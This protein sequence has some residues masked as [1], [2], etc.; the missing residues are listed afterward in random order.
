MTGIQVYAD[1]E[2]DPKLFVQN[3]SSEHMYR[4]VATPP[5]RLLLYKEELRHPLRMT[6]QRRNNITLAGP[7]C[8]AQIFSIGACAAVAMSSSDCKGGANCLDNIGIY[9]RHMHVKLW[10]EVKHLEGICIHALI[11]LGDWPRLLWI[12]SSADCVRFTLATFDIVVE[13]ACRDPR[14]QQSHILPIPV[15]IVLLLSSS[16][17]EKSTF[18]VRKKKAERTKEPILPITLPPTALLELL[19][20]H[21]KRM[22]RHGFAMM[23][24]PLALDPQDPNPDGVDGARDEAEEAED[25]VD[26]EIDGETFREPDGD[27]RDEE[28]DEE[29]QN[30][31]EGVFA[32]G[33]FNSSMMC[34]ICGWGSPTYEPTVDEVEVN[35]V[36]YLCIT[37]NSY[38]NG[39]RG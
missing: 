30:L 26:P 20:E 31:R 2:S 9:R 29:P 36:G 15:D 33:G 6:I 11:R 10:S 5:T 17:G 4:H 35:A 13:V 21:Q 32:H 14:R 7:D 1:V 28:G 38:S 3:R 34:G 8:D 39:D 27:G 19:A 22:V 18:R 23:R 16:N 25:D 37:V 12:N 24:L